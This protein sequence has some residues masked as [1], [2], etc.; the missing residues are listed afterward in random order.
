MLLIA[1]RKD[2]FD[3]SVVPEIRLNSAPEQFKLNGRDSLVRISLHYTDGDGD[4]GLEPADTAAPFNYGGKFFYNLFINVY[5]VENGSG[6]KIPIP[7]S[8]DTVHFNDRIRNLTPT[9]KNKAIFGD[10]NISLKAEPYPGIKPD[11]MYYT[12]Q[13]ADRNLHLSNTIQTGVMAFSY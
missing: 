9:G 1:C 4:I 2:G 8:S 13:L 11:S 12:I 5:A 6:K 10:I 3:A 7:F